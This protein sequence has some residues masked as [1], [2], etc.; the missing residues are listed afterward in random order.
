MSQRNPRVSS[1]SNESAVSPSWIIARNATFRSGGEV[2]A[3]FASLLFF[4]AMARKLGESGFGDFMFALSLTTVFI[5][6]SGFGTE[7]LMAR[8]I[9]RER[10]RTDHYLSNITAIKVVTSILLLAVVAAIVNLAGY[11][12][13]TRYAVYIIGVGVAIENI[14]R[15]WHSVLQA[16]ERMEFISVALIL[17]RFVTAGVGIAVLQAGGGLIAVSVV[18]SGGAVVGLVSVSLAL[19]WFVVA[20]RTNIDRSKWLPL[21]KAGVPIG[22]AGLLFTVLLRLDVSL[23][24]FLE[25]GDNKEVGV[26]AAAFR[27]IEATMFISWSLGAAMLPWLARH[28][29]DAVG[30]GYE[31]GLKATFALLLPIG[32]IFVLLAAPLIDLLYGKEYDNAVLPL[33]LLGALTVLYGVNYFAATLLIARDRPGRWNRVLLI[34]L[35]QNIGFNLIL[36]P[37]YGAAGAAFTATLSGILLAVLGIRQAWKTIGPIRLTQTFAGA[38]VGGAAMTAAILLSDFPLVPAAILGFVAYL[39]GLLVIERLAFAEDLRMLI[40][41]IR[42]RGKPPESAIPHAEPE[43]PGIKFEA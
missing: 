43:P 24:S 5:L 31:L 17:Q 4:I 15:T 26:Y 8:E 12:T 27:L 7:S 38:L 11:P 10:S 39:V 41:M 37:K 13:E 9:A 16:Y 20:P 23:I 28:G 21:I 22:L 3:K 34:V 40:R 14:G 18:F 29:T 1:S 2:L 30:R 6:A 19:R 36:I 35:V 42:T 33:Q 32:L 25:G